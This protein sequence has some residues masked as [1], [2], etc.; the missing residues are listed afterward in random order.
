MLQTLSI[1]L[2]VF[3]R[4]RAEVVLGIRKY[5]TEKASFVEVLLQVY[6]L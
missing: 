3:F 4:M 5:L 1:F 2:Q 6:H